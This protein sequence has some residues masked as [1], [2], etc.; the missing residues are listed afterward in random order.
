VYKCGVRL[1]EE[2]QRV[3]LLLMERKEDIRH[4]ELELYID[5]WG[6][7]GIGRTERNRVR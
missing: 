1:S 2:I 5:G 4:I 3:Q 6:I 7:V